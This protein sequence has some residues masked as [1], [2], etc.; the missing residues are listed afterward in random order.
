MEIL[1]IRHG[2]S[3]GDLEDR[4]EGLADFKLSPQGVT[5]AE[6]IARFIYQN[7][8]LNRIYTSPLVRARE[9]ADRIAEP[10]QIPVYE[11]EG[12]IERDNGK[13]SGMLRSEALLQFPYPA[14]GRA[15]YESL[16][17]GESELQQRMRVEAFWARLCQEAPDRRIGIVT[18]SSTINML[19][20]SFLQ[21]PND[22]H[23]FLST[24]EAGI[25]FW[26]VH[27]RYRQIMF[28]NYQEHL[29][30]DH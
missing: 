27:Q 25:H 8:P 10:L 6:K 19:F 28:N 12:L 29:K 26:N 9:T 18:H 4:H 22:C 17:G 23:V 7:Y 21:L 13:L 1:V 16:H 15:Y 3:Y 5:Q 20:Q 24:A 2:Q 14:E 11:E 30:V